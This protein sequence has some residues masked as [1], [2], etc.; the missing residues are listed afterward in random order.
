MKQTVV[1]WLLENM[2]INNYISKERK[3]KAFW[4][5]EESKQMHKQQIIDAYQNG[6]SDQQSDVKSI[7]YNTNA[8]IYYNKTFKI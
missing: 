4:L 5:I 3:K 7:F 1:E 6:R 8:E 2:L